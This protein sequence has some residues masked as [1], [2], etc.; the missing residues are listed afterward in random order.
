MIWS[1]FEIDLIFYFSG[2]IKIW[3]HTAVQ[4]IIKKYGTNFQT[5]ISN[6]KQNKRQISLIKLIFCS[7]F[8]R[9]TQK[10]IFSLWI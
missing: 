5:L 1:W 6:Y 3:I 8:T 7:K 9:L 10:Q 2:K 4:K